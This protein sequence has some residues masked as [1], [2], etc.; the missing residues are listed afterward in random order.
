VAEDRLRVS[1]VIACYKDAQ[2]IP[3]MHERLTAAFAAADVGGEIIF[4]N[5]GSPDDSRQVL[6]EIAARDPNVVVITHSR[7]FGA[8]SAFTS[9]MRIATGD[10]VVLLDG[11]LQDPPELI[12][13]MIERWREGYEIVYGERVDREGRRLKLWAVKRFYRLLRRVSY[14]DVPVDAGDFGLMDR[15]AV[16]IVN[17]LPEK[18]RFM[19]GLRAWVGFRQ[20]GVPYVRPERMFGVS[21]NNFI[22]NLGWARRAIVSFSYA[23]LDLIISMALLVVGASAAALIGIVALKIADPSSAPKGT[24]T[25]IVLVL[26]I[27]GMQLLCI[28]IVGSYLGAMF[29]EIKARPAYVVDEI[30][31]DPARSEP[32]GVEQEAAERSARTSRHPSQTDA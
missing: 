21:T 18:Q 32:V 13:Q 17:A 15:R 3:I 4:V 16:D 25:L 29:E 11:D 28:S 19:R 20:T 10:A 26:F 24:T 31:N 6:A 9:G 14:V 22:K 5:D 7:P 30:L 27:G 1:A 2:A 12:P 23:P 8:Q